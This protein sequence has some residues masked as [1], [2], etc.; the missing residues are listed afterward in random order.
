MWVSIPTQDCLVSFDLWVYNF[1]LWAYSFWE[2]WKVFSYQ[3]KDFS[4]GYLE[5]K[6]L[7]TLCGLWELFSFHFFKCF[8]TTLGS[9]TL[10]M[11]GLL[12]SRDSWWPL[13]RFLEVF[14]CVTP[15]SWTQPPHYICLS[16]FKH[17]SP[18][19]QLIL[20]DP[21]FPPLKTCARKLCL[22]LACFHFLEI[23]VLCYLVFENTI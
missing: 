4:T 13:C 2:I 23:T 3:Y 12:L 14:F 20:L 15:C 6:Y 10:C 19:P 8:C 5:C 16:L 11:S 9:F 1:C 21:E 7:T 22:S 17:R 18:F